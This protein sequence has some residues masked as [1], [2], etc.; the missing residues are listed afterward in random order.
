MMDT[1]NT[2]VLRMGEWLFDWILLLPRDLGLLAVA[3]IT[4]LLLVVVR[5]WTTDQDWLQ[6][7]KADQRVLKRLRREA[8]QRGDLA[9]LARHK[10]LG[11]QIGF[12]KL[13]MEGRPLLWAIM[14]VL[15]L[16]AWAYERMPWLP[17]EAGTEIRVSLRH[18][19]S[20]TGALAHLVPIE[21]VNST[22]WLAMF[23]RDGDGQSSSAVWQLTMKKGRHNLMLVSERGRFMHVVTVGEP[24]RTFVEQMHTEVGGVSS[25]VELRPRKLFG[26]VPGLDAIGLPPWL[27]GYL[28]L[29]VALVPVSKRIFRLQ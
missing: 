15:V 20:Q 16:A 2:V 29:T 26:M 13:G 18:P 12:R 19:V 6:R 25:H 24:G 3:L 8:K 14:P 4:A 9:A 1:L 7:A 17:P 22:N 21:G 23:D 10:A 11:Q 28:L 27:V 5:R